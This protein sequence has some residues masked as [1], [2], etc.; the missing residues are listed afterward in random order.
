MRIGNERLVE[1]RLDVD[2]GAFRCIPALICVEG[3]SDK[4]KR[5]RE[6]IRVLVEEL[7]AA[8]QR[9]TPTFGFGIA[10]PAADGAR[11]GTRR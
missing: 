1:G 5:A 9:L 10:G 6:S 2:A 7:H 11:L 4:R 3:A 8:T